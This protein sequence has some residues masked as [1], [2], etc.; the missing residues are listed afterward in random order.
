LRTQRRPRLR[1]RRPWSRRR[2]R[3]RCRRS[4]RGGTCGNRRHWF[5]SRRCGRGSRRLS[6]RNRRGGRNRSGHWR[7]CSRWR[8]GRNRGRRSRLRSRCR[9]WRR[10]GRG[11]SRS[12]GRWRG[13]CGR[14]QSSRFRRCIFRVFVRLGLRF[15]GRFFIRD[16]VK[17]PANLLGHIHRNRA[18]VRLLFCYAVPGQ[19]VDDRLCLDL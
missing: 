1:R 8:R 15:S 18:R 11:R 17:V 6:G 2:S 5:R 9:R 13:R 4:R 7:W 19:E 12:H 10:D 3:Y 14:A 16:A